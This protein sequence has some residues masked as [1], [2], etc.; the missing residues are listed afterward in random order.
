MAELG[1]GLE[2]IILKNLLKG[3][4]H[5]QQGLVKAAV[6]YSSAVISTHLT[7]TV[8]KKSNNRA[9]AF[10][11]LIRLVEVI[12]NSPVIRNPISLVLTELCCFRTQEDQEA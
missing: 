6:I 3:T 4:H 10:V 5:C 11:M 9:K 1:T 2:I 7:Y 8:L 12:C